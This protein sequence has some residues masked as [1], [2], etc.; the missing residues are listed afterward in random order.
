MAEERRS[1]TGAPP[2]WE[3]SSAG[4]IYH[5]SR[6]AKVHHGVAGLPTVTIP[7]YAGPVP[8][9]QCWQEESDTVATVKAKATVNSMVLV[10][11]LVAYEYLDIPKGADRR[12]LAVRHL[13]GDRENCAA[14]NLEFV[15][16]PRWQDWTNR[17]KY[18]RLAQGPYRQHHKRPATHER[19]VPMLFVD[20]ASLS[21]WHPKVPLTARRRK[22]G[23][24]I[25]GTPDESAA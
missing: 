24:Q 13:D 15:A 23:A 20:A 7:G 22:E 16:D 14:D 25:A 2:G 18:L 5:H 10:E 12:G 6:R 17:R 19:H 4:V 1:L 8:T 21:G 3:A 9:A 11:E